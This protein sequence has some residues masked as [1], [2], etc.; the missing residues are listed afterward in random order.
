[1]IQAKINKELKA[2]DLLVIQD[3]R[4]QTPLDLRPLRVQEGTLDTGDYSIYGLTQHIT[5]E[6]KSLQ[7]LVMCV[8][9]ERERFEREIMRL[10]AYRAKVLVIEGSESQILLKQYRGDCHPNSIIGSVIGW[11]ERGLP[12]YWAGDAL[13]ASVFVQRFLTISAKRRWA[14]AYSFLECQ[15]RAV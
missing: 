1:M 6:R 11:Q 13:N 10:M 15:L 2:E 8:G 14:E 4:E 5:V 12:V 9:R 3:T 7:D